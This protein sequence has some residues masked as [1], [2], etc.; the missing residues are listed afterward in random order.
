[1]ANSSHWP[2]ATWD[3]SVSSNYLYRAVGKSYYREVDA[4]SRTCAKVRCYE[5]LLLTA[6]GRIHSPVRSLPEVAKSD[7]CDLRSFRGLLRVPRRTHAVSRFPRPYLLPSLVEQP[8]VVPL[9]HFLACF[10][11]QKF[12]QRLILVI[13]F[14]V[15]LLG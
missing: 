13:D 15:F 9:A 7:R 10:L 6:T 11:V 4:R 14:Q 8:L 5:G 1:M 12:P 3:R 2:N